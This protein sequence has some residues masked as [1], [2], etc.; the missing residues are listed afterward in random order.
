M[1]KYLLIAL[2]ACSPAFAEPLPYVL[3]NTEVHDLAAPA[4]KR[5]Y[6]VY[7]GL[8]ASYATSTKRYPVLFVTDAPYA[9][10]LIRSLTPRLGKGSF[11]LEEFIVIGLSYAKGET[12]EYSRRRDY[13]PNDKAE[14]GLQSDMPDRK[15]AFGE[16]EGYRRFIADTVF[17]FVAKQYRA[18]M[19]RKVFAGHSYG[20][21]LGT[22]ILLTEPTMFTHYI[23]GS[24]SFWYGDKVMFEREKAYNA[25]HKDLP[26]HVFFAV[27]GLETVKPGSKDARYNERNDLVRDMLAFERILKSRK[28]ASLRVQ[29]QVLDGEDHLSV[30][31]NITTRGL[32]WAL[33]A[34][35]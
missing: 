15:P 31:P 34:N 33:P 9:F 4:L 22:H 20:S 8:P 24:P 5:D 30:G 12:S 16:A 2:F 13:T 14:P 32:K 6:Q 35:K 25:S 26:A 11:G 29:S 10:P 17:P 19:S 1:K 21:L 3:A 27:G 23:L 28:Y 7:V 18:D